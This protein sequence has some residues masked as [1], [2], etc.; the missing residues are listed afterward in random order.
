MNITSLWVDAMSPP[1]TWFELPCYA[2]ALACDLADQSTTS[3]S[4]SSSPCVQKY[5][6]R[7]VIYVDESAIECD[8]AF[9]T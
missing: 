7:V 4:A 3:S 2:E 5:D 9:S 6:P 1:K 8:E